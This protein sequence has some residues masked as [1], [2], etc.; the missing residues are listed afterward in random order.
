MGVVLLDVEFA[1]VPE[2]TAV[3]KPLAWIATPAWLSDWEIASVNVF[4]LPSV[5]VMN[6]PSSEPPCCVIPDAVL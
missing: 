5:N 6:V 1:L 4:E 3:V 2:L